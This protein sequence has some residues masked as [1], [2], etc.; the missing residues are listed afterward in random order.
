MVCFWNPNRRTNYGLDLR[1]Y[2]LL[3][4]MKQLQQKSKWPLLR[5]TFAR[6]LCTA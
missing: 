5:S 6:G 2:Q 3:I 1:C 4:M